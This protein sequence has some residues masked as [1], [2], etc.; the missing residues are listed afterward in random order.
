[1]S[2]VAATSDYDSHW[3]RLKI[4]PLPVILIVS[5]IVYLSASVL[6]I[7]IASFVVH[8]KI[9]ASMMTNAKYINSLT[10]SRTGFPLIVV[11]PQVAMIVPTILVA[12]LSPLGFR[13]RLRLVRGHWPLWIWG[14][15]ALA[16]PLIGMISSLIVGLFMKDSESLIEMTRIFRDLANNG[17]LIPLAMMIGI[18]PG[19]CEELLFRGY[20]QSR[21]TTRLGGFVG[22]LITSVVFAA[23]HMDLVHSTAVFALGVWLGWLCW[24]SGSIFPAMIAHFFNN[25]ASV[26]AVAIGP[27]PGSNEASVEAVAVIGGILFL[28]SGA[29][30]ATI[31][32]AWH[33]RLSSAPITSDPPPVDVGPYGEPL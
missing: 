22:I 28:G 4:W 23:F 11:I 19:V 1:M 33:Y 27:E 9:D 29:F 13:T 30:L 25:S 16:T 24:Q 14:L 7:L 21:L 6:A 32:S 2:Q 3:Q 26:F 17:F 18:T 5:L 12:L 10:Q 20:I 31:A 15:A 8:G